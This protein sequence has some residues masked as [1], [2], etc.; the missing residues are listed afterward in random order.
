MGVSAPSLHRESTDS[1]IVL[2]ANNRR[3][4]RI[5]RD[6]TRNIE[7]GANWI[8]DLDKEDLERHP[9]WR[10]WLECD[11]LGPGGSITPTIGE[12]DIGFERIY[13]GTTCA[14][15]NISESGDYRKRRA[16]YEQTKR[17]NDPTLQMNMIH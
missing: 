6:D 17:K 11:M 4:G 2:E 5:R 7:L 14:L 8:H 9:L 10:E 12:M 16:Q 3:G 15:Y 13:N 1:L